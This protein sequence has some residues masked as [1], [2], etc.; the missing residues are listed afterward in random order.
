MTIC[1]APLLLPLLLPHL[2][3][4]HVANLQCCVWSLCHI[5][6]GGGVDSLVTQGCGR[7]GLTGHTRVCG[8]VDSPVTQ[9]CVEVW[10]HWSHKGVWRCG[11]T[12]HTKASYGCMLLTSEV[13]SSEHATQ[14]HATQGPVAQMNA[15]RL[16]ATCLHRA[17]TQHTAHMQVCAPHRVYFTPLCFLWWGQ[18]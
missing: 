17:D 2:W 11:L 3:T 7:C 14:V 15:K 12:G 4:A 18:W 6:G 5:Q 13:L 1:H 16:L 8:G 9:G 10:T